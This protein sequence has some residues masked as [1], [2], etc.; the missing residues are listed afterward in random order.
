MKDVECNF[1]NELI[2][3]GEIFSNF[4]AA[5]DYLMT[6]RDS[7]LSDFLT[8]KFDIFLLMKVIVSQRK[9]DMDYIIISPVVPSDVC[10]DKLTK[11]NGSRI[12]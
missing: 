12:Y 1:I 11:Y 7:E 6:H 8:N 9:R 2:Q 10:Y 4:K 3:T 5:I